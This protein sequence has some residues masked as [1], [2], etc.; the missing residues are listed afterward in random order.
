MLLRYCILNTPEGPR[1]LR[2]RIF[3]S[4]FSFYKY[5]HIYQAQLVSINDA[6]KQQQTNKCKDTDHCYM[7]KKM[8]VYRKELYWIM[9]RKSQ[10]SLENKL[11]IYKQSWNLSG[12]MVYIVGI[13][14]KL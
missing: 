3:N 10:L 12:P 4:P 11:L 5:F 14:V 7:T 2:V 9:G 8:F 6:I 13:S 1:N